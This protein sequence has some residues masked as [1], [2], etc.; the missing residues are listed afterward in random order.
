MA[1]YKFI[2]QISMVAVILTGLVFILQQNI[3]LTPP[4]LVIIGLHLAISMFFIAQLVFNENFYYARYIKRH[5]IISLGVVALICWSLIILMVFYPSLLANNTYMNHVT[6]I[7]IIIGFII[8]VVIG[9]PRTFIK[10][11][12]RV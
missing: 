11:V 3:M 9:I 10:S 6:I 2:A 8:I 12:R 7:S 5:L 4:M 1:D